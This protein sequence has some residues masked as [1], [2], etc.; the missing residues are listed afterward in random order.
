MK[1]IAIIIGTRPEAIKLLPVFLAFRNSYKFEPVIVSTGQHLEMVNQIFDFF[2]IKPEIELNVMLENQSLGDLTSNLCRKLQNC[3]SE[4][5]FDAIMVQGDTTSAFIAGLIGFYEKAKV[6]HVEAGLRTFDKYSPFPEEMNRKLLSSLTDIHFCPTETAENALHRENIFENVFNVGNTVIDALLLTKEKVLADSGRYEKYFGDLFDLEKRI[7][8]ITCHRR[9]NFGR[10]LENI[11]RALMEIADRHK[12][13]ELVYPVHLN[14][15][16]QKPVK[17]RLQNHKNIHL[18]KPI[19]YDQ[20]VYLMD[21]SYLILTDSGGVQEEAPSLGKPVLVMRESTERPEGIEA[22]C[23]RLV[24]TKK[25]NIIAHAERLLTDKEAYL[26]MA[27]V[28]NPYGDGKSSKRIL[29]I[30]ESILF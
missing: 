7:I 17:D 18:L 1:K 4:N 22:G 9:E 29:E 26:K 14:P 19:A 13:C 10:T 27:K 2:G 8:L 12:D 15:N 11:C 21:K 20:M 24:G 6:I 25:E 23:A 28:E 3:F 16:V 30:C 5:N